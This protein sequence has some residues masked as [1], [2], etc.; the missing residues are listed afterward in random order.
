MFRASIQLLSSLKS[1]LQ[2]ADIS[3]DGSCQQFHLA[4]SC[5][6]ESVAPVALPLYDSLPGAETSFCL[7]TPHCSPT[8]PCCKTASANL[9]LLELSRYRAYITLWGISL[10]A[11]H[12][13]SGVNTQKCKHPD[14][15]QG[16]YQLLE[17]STSDGLHGEVV[18]RYQRGLGERFLS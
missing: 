15:D 6:G 13:S 5:H 18:D 7:S 11:Q 16:A 9:P 14:K 1:P 4:Y 17:F 8:A 10:H 3:P 12:P 2:R